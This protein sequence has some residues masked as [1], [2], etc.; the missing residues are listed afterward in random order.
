MLMVNKP[1]TK[2]AFNYLAK[3]APTDDGFRFNLSLDIIAIIIAL[4]LSFYLTGL[5]YIN[6]IANLELKII[7]TWG[8]TFITA[9]I[10]YICERLF[11]G[12]KYIFDDITK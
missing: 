4:F 9:V 10:C 3:I 2:S 8:I 12:I 5:N 7:T 6:E 11:K 1:D